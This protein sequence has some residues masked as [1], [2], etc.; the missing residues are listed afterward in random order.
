MA[1][2]SLWDYAEGKKQ[3]DVAEALGYTQGAIS[4]MLR[5]ERELTVRVKRGLPPILIETNPCRL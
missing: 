1:E 4:K 5:S 3:K 2:V